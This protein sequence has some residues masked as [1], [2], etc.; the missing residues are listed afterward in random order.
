MRPEEAFGIIVKELRCKKSISQEL[1][2]EKSNLDR[3]YISMLER[4]K[5]SPTILTIFKISS[6]LEI[7]SSDLIKQV[8]LLIK[9]PPSENY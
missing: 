5:K 6:A 9:E 1:L 8:E 2:A 4:G 3:T 7:A